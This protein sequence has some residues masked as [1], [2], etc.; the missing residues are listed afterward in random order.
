MLQQ[1]KA[2]DIIQ[3]LLPAFMEAHETH[4]IIMFLLPMNAHEFNLTLFL[5]FDDLEQTVFWS[6]SKFERYPKHIAFY[7]S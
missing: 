2:V 1:N 5:A 3:I 7:F 4:P 6:M